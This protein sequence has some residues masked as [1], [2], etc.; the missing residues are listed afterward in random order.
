MKLKNN[1]SAFPWLLL[2]LFLFLGYATG[3]RGQAVPPRLQDALGQRQENAMSY[4][5]IRD[6][7]SSNSWAN[8]MR[9]I[10]H[11]Q[12]V[13]SADSVIQSE[14]AELF[15]AE[16]KNS[17]ALRLQ[18][19]SLQNAKP[20]S[21]GAKGQGGEYPLFY[22]GLIALMV[23]LAA[24]GGYLLYLMMNRKKIPAAEEPADKKDLENAITEYENKLA[25]I[26]QV[27]TD[28]TLERDKTTSE[29]DELT[30]TLQRE[31]TQRA[32]YAEH[33]EKLSIEHNHLKVNMETL[34]K[35]NITLKKEVVKCQ[36]QV[37]E[38]PD[39]SSFITEIETLHAQL[40]EVNTQKNNL[41]NSLNEVKQAY[42]AAVNNTPANHSSAE[43]LNHLKDAVA[44]ME[45]E[46]L[47]AQAGNAKLADE[48][49]SLQAK[50]KIVNDSLSD[51]RLALARHDSF[52]TSL[53]HQ[54]EQ[55]SAKVNDFQTLQNE[56]E[57]LRKQ[58]A[59]FAALQNQ[60]GFLE[61][62]KEVLSK[63][64]DETEK[65]LQKRITIENELKKL[66]GGLGS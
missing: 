51:A 10:H 62:E 21:G 15:S 55:L 20:V 17:K 1:C 31:R 18:L 38:P 5:V 60:M 34:L 37:P 33:Y 16:L 8:L 49:Q 12:R 46:L 57:M 23:L 53:Q 39:A 48:N 56:V 35:E 54:I 24:L 40:A 66:M 44:G 64:L 26:S 25:E 52:T 27:L 61:A 4:Q 45:G 65:E 43:E 7:M 36:S 63:K 22:L 28:L 14:Y 30:K 3:V 9:L 2:P 58:A 59:G 29:I 47:A 41:Q 6:T 13:A 19:D 50:L 32:T 42:E 11:L